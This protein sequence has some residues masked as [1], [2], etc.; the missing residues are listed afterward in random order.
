LGD[1]FDL[2]RFHD[3]LLGSGSVP[4]PIL[5]ELVADW[6]GRLSSSRT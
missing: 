2:R 1:R 3:T 4:L 6:I 5:R